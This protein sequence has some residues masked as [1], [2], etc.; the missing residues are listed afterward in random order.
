[1]LSI[2][3]LEDTGDSW[4]DLTLTHEIDAL[5]KRFSQLDVCDKITLK[6]K[7][8]ELSF[9]DTALMC[10]Y[11]RESQNKECTKVCEIHQT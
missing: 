10:S 6:N 5:L 2:R 7:V 8:C 4:E 9:F 1:M 11:S 3:S